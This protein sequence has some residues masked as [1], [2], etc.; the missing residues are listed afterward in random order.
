MRRIKVMASE[1]SIFIMILPVFSG[2]GNL[3]E[4][5]YGLVYRL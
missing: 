3:Q 4:G 2:K 1:A 5:K